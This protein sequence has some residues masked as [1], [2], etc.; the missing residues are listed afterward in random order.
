MISRS[1]GF[2]YAMVMVMSLCVSLLASGQT[3]THKFPD[4]IKAIR[5]LKHVQIPGTRL[6][7]IPPAGYLLSNELPALEKGDSLSIHALDLK[8]SFYKNDAGMSEQDFRAKGFLVLN[9]KELKV[10]GYSAKMAL[11]QK[12]PSTRLWMLD[13]G[14][15]SFSLM[16]TAVFPPSNKHAGDEI[17]KALQT[18]WYDKKLRAV[19]FASV[20][21][22]LDDSRSIFKFAKYSGN[23]YVYSLGGVQQDKYDG[24]PYFTVTY[25]PSNGQRPEILADEALTSYEQAGLQEPD[26]NEPSDASTNHYPSFQRFILGDVSNERTL[27]YQHVVIINKMA[28]IMQGITTV[29]F[30]KNLLEFKALSN[31]VEGNPRAADKP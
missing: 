14:D 12:D 21:F 18:V 27:L 19:D 29:D 31:T 25:L 7:I 9:Y 20:V 3:D 16:I 4:E 1:S 22:T 15:S 17:Q 2:L 28:V 26:I 24:K 23:V 8:G 13:F 11:L 6:F 5:T 30:E 10:N